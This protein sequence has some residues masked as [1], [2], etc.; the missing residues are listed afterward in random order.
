[1]K[2]SLSLLCLDFVNVAGILIEVINII[3]SLAK[4][5]E[6]HKSFYKI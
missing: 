4:S 5:T 3:A 2:L 6:L 1:M